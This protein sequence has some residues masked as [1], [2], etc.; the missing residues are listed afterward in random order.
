MIGAVLEINLLGIKGA[1]INNTISIS[2]TKKITA[3]KKNRIEKG[4]RALLLGSNPH[5]KGEHFSR[6]SEEWNVI[7]KAIDRTA[8]GIIKAVI[9]V[10]EVNIIL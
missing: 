4:I 5:S 3:N 1:G 10:K 9:K 8:I 6:S 2:N 7:I